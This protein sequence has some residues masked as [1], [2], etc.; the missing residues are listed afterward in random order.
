MFSGWKAS[1]DP[2][3]PLKPCG[4]MQISSSPT[5]VPGP[6]DRTQALNPL[7]PTAPPR[8][9]RRTRL[10][11]LGECTMGPV[12]GPIR[13]QD[14]VPS[15]SLGQRKSSAGSGG[16]GA[17]ELVTDRCFRRNPKNWGKNDSHL[18]P[19]SDSY[20]LL[21]V[22]RFYRAHDSQGSFLWLLDVYCILSCYMIHP[23][24]SLPF[25]WTRILG[26]IGRQHR[27]GRQRTTSIDGLVLTFGTVQKRRFLC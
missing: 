27:P 26:S 11:G 3:P 17:E 8:F 25:A 20:L 24:L 5:S 15:L 12:F 6:S 18:A 19:R 16:D 14:L 1:F 13:L 9:R 4:I 21:Q 7:N 2:L 23:C 22:K 10:Q